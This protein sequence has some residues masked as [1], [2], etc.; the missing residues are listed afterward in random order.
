MPPGPQ[1]NITTQAHLTRH[2]VGPPHSCTKHN[3]LV[4]T[5]CNPRLPVQT[6]AQIEYILP[7]YTVRVRQIHGA[8]LDLVQIDNKQ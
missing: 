4:Y 2:P 8:D 1:V 3:D 7:Y 5:R 6:L